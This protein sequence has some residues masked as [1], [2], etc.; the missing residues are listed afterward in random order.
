[1]DAPL[2]ATRALPAIH[3]LVGIHARELSGRLQAHRLKLFP[4]TAKKTLRTFSSSEVAQL[5]GVND[6]YLRRLSL[7]NKGPPIQVGP[8]G[9]RSYTSADIQA[10]RVFLDAG[11]KPDRK[12]LPWRTAGEHLQV[13]TVVNFKGGSGKTTTAA[14]L[15]QYLALRGYR[16][17]AIDL[18]PQASLSALHGV[19]PEFDVGENE[20]LYGAIRYTDGRRELSEIIRKT[21]GGAYIEPA[22]ITVGQFLDRWLEHIKPRVSPR[23]HERYGEIVRKNLDPILG[24]VVLTKLRPM[25]ISD[26]Y[27][28]A[29]SC[30]RRDGTGGL[31]PS[32]VR[33]MHVI[34]KAS[35]CAGKCWL[36]IRSI[37][38]ILPRSSGAP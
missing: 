4:P 23:T 26:A 13:V 12:Y 22:R 16:V 11:G 3:E 20:T 24:A 38:S 30:G 34:L 27:A 19:Q 8:N 33:Y 6:G 29:L 37:R 18:D 14:H 36:A 15:S 28:K 5:I 1:V 7:E 2:S 10:L 17:L 31:S 25:Q 21:R 35:M 32:T 9:R